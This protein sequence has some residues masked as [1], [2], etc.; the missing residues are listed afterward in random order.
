MNNS[1]VKPVSNENDQKSGNRPSDNIKS[2]NIKVVVF[3]GSHLSITTL[4]MLLNQQRLS[5]VVLSPVASEF[6]Q[7]LLAWLQQMNIVYI[8]LTTDPLL[9]SQAVVTITSWQAQVAI[10]FDLESSLIDQHAALFNYGL[11]HC[12]CA[13]YPAYQGPMPL[14][15]QLRDGQ[16]STNFTLQKANAKNN[17]SSHQIA[18]SHQIDIHPL[19]TYKSLENKVL[20]DITPTINQLLQQLA[21][22]QGNIELTTSVDKSSTMNAL[23]EQDLKVVWKTMTSQQI[24]DLAR[25]GNPNFGGCII[26]LQNTELNLLQATSVNHATYGVPAGTICHTGEPE[27]VIIATSDGAIRL[28][29]ISNA[30]GIFSGLAFCDRFEISAG[31]AFF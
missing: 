15:W 30:D 23:Q 11:Y 26:T 7:Q 19:D 20:T 2:D 5:G 3:A 25:A 16:T 13:P 9:A 4:N 24:C 6:N 28:D 27:G 1:K 22:Q 18:L 10:S 12:H 29:I 14:Y 17:T 31:M 21:K 8:Q